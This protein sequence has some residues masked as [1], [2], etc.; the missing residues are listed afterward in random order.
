[1][2][3]L[4]PLR[5]VVIAGRVMS[6]HHVDLDLGRCRN[7]SARRVTLRKQQGSPRSLGLQV[8]RV[9]AR[10]LAEPVTNRGA[11]HTEDFAGPTPA[12]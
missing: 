4:T 10:R 7:A 1:M 2:G 3:P 11:F 12:V 5:G 9:D 8:S 6:L